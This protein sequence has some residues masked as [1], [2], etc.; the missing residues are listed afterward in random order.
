MTL[1]AIEVHRIEKTMAEF[2]ERVRP[3]PNIRDELDIAYRLSGQSIEIFEIRPH[4]DNP[5]KKMESPV[6]KAR[7][8]KSRDN[9][10]AYWQRADLKWHIY[11]PNAEVVTLADFL[12]VVEKD[13][14][15]CFFG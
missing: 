11:E 12:S 6:A 14:Y 7:Y 4:W 13:E 9:W 8:F 1:S 3:P 15:G 5:K 10:S 2:L